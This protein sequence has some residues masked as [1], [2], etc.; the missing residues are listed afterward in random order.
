MTDVMTVRIALPSRPLG[1]WQATHFRA[2]AAHGSFAMGPRHIDYVAVLEPGIVEL[3]LED[4]SERY[5]AVDTG[6]VVK[7]E[8]EVLVSTRRALESHDLVELRAA[9]REVFR[10]RDESELR[11]RAAT[12]KLEVG[13]VRRLYELEESRHG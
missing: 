10:K 4:E 8:R 6:I 5:I 7:R 3:V 2:D 13:F 1:V 9:V 12:S 11:A